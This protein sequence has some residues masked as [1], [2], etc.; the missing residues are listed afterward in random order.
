MVRTPS[1]DRGPHP[2]ILN[3]TFNTNG[4]N[5]S[6]VWDSREV[7]M[8]A[9][10]HTHTH[11]HTL[12]AQGLLIGLEI[13][14]HLPNHL[15]SRFLCSF[16]LFFPFTCDRFQ[17]FKALW[18]PSSPSHIQTHTHTKHNTQRFLVPSSNLLVLWVHPQEKNCLKN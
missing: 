6:R 10:T 9:N 5:K 14:L 7:Q 16:H 13:E 4:D 12:P 3:S 15:L 11:T 1:P 8:R 18:Y 2:T 17:N